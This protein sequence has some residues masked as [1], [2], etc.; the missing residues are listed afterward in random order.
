MEGGHLAKLSFPILLCMALTASTPVSVAITIAAFAIFT[1]NVSAS[2]YA[3]L[4]VFL[5]SFAIF[6]ITSHIRRLGQGISVI[7][8]L[9]SMIS[10]AAIVYLASRTGI[11][12]ALLGKI[13]HAITV[14]W[15]YDH[16]IYGRSPLIALKVLNQFP[17]GTGYAGSTQRNVAAQIIGVPFGESNLGANVYLESLSFFGILPLLALLSG[18]CRLIFNPV[19]ASNKNHVKRAALCAILSILFLD[20][21]FVLPQLWA[22]ALSAIHYGDPDLAGS[23]S[24]R[25]TNSFPS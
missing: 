1:L 4:I 23:R 9:V 8:G 12:V 18:F 6:S 17:L 2:G 19:R 3:Y 25:L 21:L 20:V 7:G 15:D 16:D 10:I 11:V 13:S 14:M 24:S 22:A 5:V